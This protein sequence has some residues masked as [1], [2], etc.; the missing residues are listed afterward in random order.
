MGRTDR[1]DD[2]PF[3][4]DFEGDGTTKLRLRVR[5]KLREFMGEYTDD[6]LVVCF[7]IYEFIETWLLYVKLCFW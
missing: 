7:L 1:A 2:I 4:L 5:E 3:R 6:T